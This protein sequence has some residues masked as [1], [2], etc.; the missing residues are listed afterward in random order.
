MEGLLCVLMCFWSSTPQ[1]RRGN[2][3]YIEVLCGLAEARDGYKLPRAATKVVHALLTAWP[4]KSPMLLSL[5][6]Q[7]NAPARPTGRLAHMPTGATDAS[8]RCRTA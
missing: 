4:K 1:V 6:P 5:P 7:V 8:R 2:L 3:N